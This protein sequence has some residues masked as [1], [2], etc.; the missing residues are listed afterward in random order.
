MQKQRPFKVPAPVIA[1]VNWLIP[2]SGYL[3]L[4]QVA[5]GLTIGF[6]I[7]ILFFLGILIGGIHVVDPPNFS[8][9][10]G[11]LIRTILEKPWYIGQFMSGAIGLI[12]GWLGPLQPPSHARANDIGTLYTAVAGMLNLL[13]TIDSSYRSTLD[14]PYQPSPAEGQ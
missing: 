7:L 11:N 3:M 12:C 14:D 6:T 4:G 9:A 10:H 13:A 2:G 1:I 5:R 8:L